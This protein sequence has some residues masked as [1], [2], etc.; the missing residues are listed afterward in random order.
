MGSNKAH[1]AWDFPSTPYYQFFQYSIQGYV[2]TIVLVATEA[3][4]LDGYNLKVHLGTR[5]LTYGNNIIPDNLRAAGA[6]HKENGDFQLLSLEDS[7]S[8]E[9]LTPMNNLIFTQFGRQD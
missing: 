5:I 7:T 9:L 2:R 4:T 3:G 1:R 8:Q 6:K